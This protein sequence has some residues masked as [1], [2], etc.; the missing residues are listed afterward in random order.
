MC[1]NGDAAKKL[2][3]NMA[4]CLCNAAFNLEPE[5][6]WLPEWRYNKARQEL[7]LSCPNCHFRTGAFDNKSAA[8]AFW[9]ACNRS[10]DAYLLELW[11]RDYERQREE[12]KAA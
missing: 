7:L 8:I 2:P 1:M 3:E 12:A 9:S 11:C 4:T 6:K 5:M 10:G